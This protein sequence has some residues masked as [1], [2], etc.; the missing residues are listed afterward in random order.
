MNDKM[1]RNLVVCRPDFP[2][3]YVESFFFKIN[4][5]QKGYGLWIKFTILKFTQANRPAMASVWATRISSKDRGLNAGMRNSIEFARCDYDE[6][7]AGIKAGRSSFGPGFTKGHLQDAF[8]NS[9]K[10]DI[11]FDESAEPSFVYPLDFIYSSKLPRFKLSTPYDLSKAEGHFTVNSKRMSFKNLPLMQ[12]HNW[13]PS[14]SS[15]YMWAHCNA[16]DN[17]PQSIFEG[18]SARMDIGKFRT[19]Y[20]SMGKL[21]HEGKI[22]RFA[23]PKTIFTKD[24]ATNRN[25]WSFTFTNRTHRLT[26]VLKADRKDFAGL[27]YP[28]PDLTHRVCVNCNIAGATFELTRIKDGELLAKLSSARGA[29]LELICPENRPDVCVYAPSFDPDFEP[30]A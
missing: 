22:Y 12:G 13:G 15:D 14:H 28:N 10:W 18:F 30:E 16:F 26:G 5:P 1:R 3:G 8:G 21:T 2:G 20:L 23:G 7:K 9:I 19:P 6:D 29:M 4:N 11:R 24:V 27:M 17:A 25:S